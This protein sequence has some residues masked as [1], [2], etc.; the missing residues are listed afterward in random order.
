MKSCSTSR[1]RVEASS[2]VAFPCAMV[3]RI[4]PATLD[5]ER[6]MIRDRYGIARPTVLY[7]APEVDETGSVD[8]GALRRELSL[9]DDGTKVA[10]LR[11]E[12]AIPPIETPVVWSTDDGWASFT[13][14]DL[15][16]ALTIEL[17]LQGADI[18]EELTGIDGVNDSGQVVGTGTVWHP[19]GDQRT[20]VFLLDTL[21]LATSV[22]KGD[23]NDDGVVDTDD[24]LQVIANWGICA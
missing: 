9:P 12:F 22:L 7:N 2:N 13:E 8:R 21:A 14:L 23:V 3:D 10:G 4:T 16:E 19:D 17:A 5:R 15:N 18:W 24:V 20:A 1:E 6:K 11:K